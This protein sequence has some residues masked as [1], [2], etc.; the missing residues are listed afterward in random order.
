MITFI[1]FGA[2]STSAKKYKQT[3]KA[4]LKNPSD[5]AFYNVFLVYLHNKWFK[6]C[7]NAKLSI[8]TFQAV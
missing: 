8:N 2:H 5:P 1:L 7:D 6:P 3:Q 4:H